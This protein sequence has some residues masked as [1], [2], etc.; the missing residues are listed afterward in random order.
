[1][2]DEKDTPDVAE[3]EKRGMRG[4]NEK[5]RL[6]V[7]AFGRLGEGG[8]PSPIEREWS[9]LIP[10]DQDVVLCWAG[11]VNRKPEP[12]QWSWFWTHIGGPP[13]EHGQK[14]GHPHII[15]CAPAAKV[16]RLLAPLAHESRVR[17]MQ[18]M[19]DGS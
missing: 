2:E 13:D 10:D 11:A 12:F 3:G 9:T 14:G 1:M 17:L 7:A 19:Y 5:A 16:E 8:G 6:S 15:M 4:W 18:A